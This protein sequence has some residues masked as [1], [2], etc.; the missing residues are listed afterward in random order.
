MSC[1]NVSSSF[2]PMSR[3]IEVWAVSNLTFVLL[4]FTLLHSTTEFPF[5]VLAIYSLQSGTLKRVSGDATRVC[6]GC[7]KMYLKHH[8]PSQAIKDVRSHTDLLCSVILC[9][10]CTICVASSTSTIIWCDLCLLVAL[11][12]C[13]HV[14]LAKCLLFGFRSSY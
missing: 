5:I 11:W 9:V 8:M 7:A 1:L 2:P 6:A 3:Q 12:F 14:E 13:F 4:S 10:G